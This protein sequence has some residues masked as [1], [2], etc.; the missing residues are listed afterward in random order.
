MGI[1]AHTQLRPRL[2]QAFDLA[3][4]SVSW[5]NGYSFFPRPDEYHLV[6][7]YLFP[8]LTEKLWV[9]MNLSPLDESLL[10]YGFGYNDPLLALKRLTSLLTEASFEP[11]W[12]IFHGSGALVPPLATLYA[13][14][15]R[16]TDPYLLIC[17]ELN[18]VEPLSNSVV[19][20]SLALNRQPAEIDVN[21]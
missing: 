19:F 5:A 6:T 9:E 2:D 1:Y 8:W 7:V 15:R 18:G 3:H 16:P 13:Q 17:D 14:Q 10:V 20:G 21:E 4:S 11:D 12:I